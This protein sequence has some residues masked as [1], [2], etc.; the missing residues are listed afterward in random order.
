MHE[1]PLH[2]VVFPD[3]SPLLRYSRPVEC[4]EA[5]MQ[6]E[7][8]FDE[9]SLFGVVS[10]DDAAPLEVDGEEDAEC[11]DGAKK[12]P[13]MELFLQ[14]TDDGTDEGGSDSDD[15]DSHD[16]VLAAECFLEPE[17]AVHRRH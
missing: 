17:N 10:A 12:Q 15:D 9:E 7:A 5:V 1:E 8:E 6:H 11:G 13:V 2:D 14:S 16:E 3:Y 4:Q